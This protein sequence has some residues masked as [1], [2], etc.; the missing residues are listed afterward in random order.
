M[1]ECECVYVCVC[2]VSLLRVSTAA[3]QLL[4][5]AKKHE[6]L[7]GYCG[8]NLLNSVDITVCC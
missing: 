4:M 2:V 5:K 7:S 3:A 6:F 8:W 1:Q